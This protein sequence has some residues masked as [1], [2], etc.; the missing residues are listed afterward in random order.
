MRNASLA[1]ST[2]NLTNSAIGM[3]TLAISYSYK[4]VGL[5]TGLLLTV[6]LA[7][8]TGLTLYF[9]CRLAEATRQYRFPGK[10]RDFCCEMRCVCANGFIKSW[11]KLL[12][13]ALVK[14][15]W[16]LLSFSIC[17]LR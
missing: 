8:V 13:G 4:I 15:S 17:W 2:F 10:L 5:G 1:S 11:A 7:F 3:G 16:L 14:L 12:Q 9:Y 6:F